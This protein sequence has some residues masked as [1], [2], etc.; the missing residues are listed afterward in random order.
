[1]E[2]NTLAA[3]DMASFRRSS[4]YYW[5]RGP[6]E[7]LSRELEASFLPI[8]TLLG[9]FEEQAQL[10]VRQRCLSPLCLFGGHQFHASG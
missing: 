7:R 9:Y 4:S 3:K 6:P 2:R 1:M 10:K 8:K 5:Q